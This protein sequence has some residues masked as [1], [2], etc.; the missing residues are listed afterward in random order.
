M[1]SGLAEPVAYTAEDDWN[2]L[3]RLVNLAVSYAEMMLVRP[4]AGLRSPDAAQ[5]EVLR[6]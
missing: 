1:L 6:C 3:G 5:H 4:K 2:S